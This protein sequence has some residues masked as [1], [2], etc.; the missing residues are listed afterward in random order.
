MTAASAAPREQENAS[1]G[2]W[3]NYRRERIADRPCLW[4]GRPVERLLPALP[5]ARLVGRWRRA[6]GPHLCACDRCGRR[7]PAI[8]GGSWTRR[9]LQVDLS[10]V[11]VLGAGD[12]LRWPLVRLRDGAV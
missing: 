9:Y 12:V 7:G 3:P 10:A 5:S 4:R 1:A 8:A 2:R 6:T 11:F